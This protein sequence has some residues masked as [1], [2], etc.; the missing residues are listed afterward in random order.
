MDNRHRSILHS[1]RR[2]PDSRRKDLEGDMAGRKLI[3][4]V[5]D[6]PDILELVCIN[7]ERAGFDVKRFTR[8]SDFMDSL[9]SGEPDLVILDLMLPDTHGTEV[10][11]ILRSSERTAGI[12]II[13]LT[14]MVDEADRVAG[15]EMGADDYVTKPFSPREL[16]ARVKA[17]LRR[18]APAGTS[19]GAIEV[20]ESLRIDPER[21]SVTLEGEE[22]EL[23]STEFRLLHALAEG[24][25]RVFSRKRLLEILW[26][27]EKY[28]TERT[29]DVHIAHLR[30]KL[31]DAGDLI[32]NVRG[33]GYRLAAG[34]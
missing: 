7:L 19:A 8:S 3:A 34:I 9:R 17:V 5:D 23:T 12:P 16:V 1:V 22:L 24:R 33:I 13:M 27:G 18:G 21:F 25:G 14:A 2:E 30:G 31:R 15:L 11:R 6:E 28:V 29:I 10:C 4:V 26:Q 32:E 20:N